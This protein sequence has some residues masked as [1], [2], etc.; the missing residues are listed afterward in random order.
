MGTLSQ[1]SFADRVR[2]RKLPDHLNT[3]DSQGIAHDMFTM[4]AGGGLEGTGW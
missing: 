4:L 3:F 1:R 2:S